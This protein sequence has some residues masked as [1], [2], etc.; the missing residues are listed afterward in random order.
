MSTLPPS[1]GEQARVIE[2]RV[3]RVTLLWFVLVAGLLLGSC[4]FSVVRLRQAVAQ[5]ADER[6]RV[7]TTTLINQLTI[8]DTLY[9]RLAQAGVRVLAS[10]LL[11]LGVPIVAPGRIWVS[12]QELPDL[13]FGTVPLSRSAP[14]V[15][16]VADQMGATATLF[17]RNGD[18]FVRAVTTVRDRQG[19]FAVGSELDPSGAPY[20]T[21]RA[22]KA[23]LGVALILGEPYFAAYEPIVDAS[24]N[25][26]GAFYAGYQIATLKEIGRIVQTTKILDHGFVALA[27]ADGSREFHS[28][29]V[30]DRAIATVLDS[31][32]M[33]SPGI[34]ETR[35]G[36]YAV[37]RRLFVPWNASIYTAIYTPDI[38]RLAIQLTIG[39]LGLTAV[40]LVAVLFLSW[41]YSQRL[42]RALIAGEIARRKAE[43]EQAESR[44][45]R[46]EAEE[47][48][49]AKGSFLANMSHELRTPMNAI[50]GYSEMLIEVAEDL[51]P[52]E[53]VPDLQKIQA[54]GKHL[55]GLINDVLDLSKIEAGRMTL[56]LEDFDL[57]TTLMDVASTV[58]P[59]VIKNGNKLRLG[60]P[61]DLGIVHADL[62]KFRQCL[63]NLLGNAT[64]FTR[65]GTITVNVTIVPS[66]A[67][68]RV[69]ASERDPAGE[70][71]QVAISDTGIGIAREQLDGLF[72]SF[73]QADSS[74]TRQYGGTGLGLAISRRFSRLM[75][76]DITVTS[77]PGVGSTFTLELP[78]RVI[79]PHA[80]SPSPE[81]LPVAAP[82]AAP[83]AVAPRA[84]VLVIDDDLASCDQVRRR[85]VRLGYG[86]EVA[87]AGEAGL[88]LARS[89]KPDVITLDVMMSG[90]D[91]WAV[92]EALK[93]DPELAAIPVVMMSLLENRELAS[94]LGAADSLTKPVHQSQL[95]QLLATIR[96]VERPRPVRLLVV[97]DEPANALLLQRILQRQGWVV[98]QAANGHEALA[99]VARERPD[100]ILLDLMMPGM[101]GLEFLDHLRRNPAAIAIPVVVLT[102]RDL[103]ED[104]LSRLHGRVREVLRKGE[105][106]AVALTEQI[107]AILTTGG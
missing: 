83:P 71:V 102:A 50:I 58:A 70:R 87:H 69:L 3:R 65:N 37:S 16:S 43:Q 56:Y 74:T 8:T 97:E 14:V 93:A 44:L 98:S 77:T 32:G 91:G 96:S 46:L 105:F 33:R 45:A 73:N 72:E 38:D 18:R 95:D 29:H 79:D 86:V 42:S 36:N 100:L 88:A 1:L 2:T 30:S 106:N 62:T 31:P 27:A 66:P 9:R 94:T 89:L 25:V 22:G 92:L 35:I 104:D 60:F 51:R 34:M 103:S 10:D 76:G 107:N 7:V 99:A 63:L 28:A 57:S 101:D 61:R 4:V 40:M 54:A 90:M 5:F 12:G 82:P 15:R 64:K 20:R 59:L 81:R 78:R 19:E 26:V 85:L 23:F 11:E 24:G 13:R 49:Q 67:S 55:L 47:A 80:E 17:V 48:N 41:L 53:F 68:D 75:G 84:T 39:V 21:L 52:E 6:V